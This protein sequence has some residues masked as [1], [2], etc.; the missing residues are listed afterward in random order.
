MFEICLGKQVKSVLG[1]GH[2]SRT[3]LILK[4]FNMNNVESSIHKASLELLK[5]A[6]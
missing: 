3:L 1:L 4:A 5:N 6:F 2:S